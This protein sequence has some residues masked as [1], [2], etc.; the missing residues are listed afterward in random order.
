MRPDPSRLSR[1]SRRE[2]LT[3]GTGVFVALSLPRA[4]RRRLPVVRRTIPVMGTIAE[5]QVIHAETGPAEAAIDAALAELRWVERTM[6]RFLATS[7]LGR[8][9]QGASR[10]A[11]TIAPATAMV[12]EAALDW[13][14]ASGGRFDPALGSASVLWGVG[15][16]RTP[17]PAGAVSRLAG[18]GLWR[19][20]D[21]ASRR[22]GAVLRYEDPDVQLDLGGIA[23][24]HAVDRAITALRRHGIRQALV[25]V[26]GDLYALGRAPDGGPWQVGIRDP[27]TPDALAGRLSVE[28]R[29]VATSGDYERYF[30]WHGRRYH[31]LLD[32]DT[33]APRL[34][35]VHSLTVLAPTGMAA[36]AAATAAFGLPADAARQLLRQP[37]PTAEVVVLT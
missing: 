4:L 34:T 16:R 25:T 28:D 24:G 19:R 9:N 8:A 15:E 7:D 26:G 14:A 12:V 31:H 5:V 29:A 2:F 33:A 18:R 36:D 22:D 27:R 17:P 30:D 13:A 35:S 3:I 21:L 11:V 6:S 37:C 1:P 20:I 32:P 23:K 10:D